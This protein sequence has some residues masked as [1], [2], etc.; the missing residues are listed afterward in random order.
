M[1]WVLS[2]V[3]RVFRSFVL[4][5]YLDFPIEFWEF[6]LYSGDKLFSR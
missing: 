3:K 1:N 2:L 5:L 4:F 6:F